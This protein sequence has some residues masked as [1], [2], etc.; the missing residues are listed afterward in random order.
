MG[1]THPWPHHLQS[2]QP[3]SGKESPFHR[4]EGAYIRTRA[5]AEGRQHT[6]MRKGRRAPTYRHA[7]RQ[8]GAHIQTCADAERRQH[9][10][11]R[12]RRRAPT[13]RHAQRQKGSYMQTRA[14][15][16]YPCG[17]A[18]PVLEDVALHSAL[19]AFEDCCGFPFS[20]KPFR[21]PQRLPLPC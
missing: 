7:Q 12:K 5:D 19:T 20:Q 6:D 14:K 10:D 15:A 16:G 2:S 1:P 3:P 9:A 4:E 21:N 18:P 11:T 8:K 13:Y 17:D